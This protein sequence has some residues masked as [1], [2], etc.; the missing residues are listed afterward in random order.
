MASLIGNI[1]SDPW[2][3]NLEFG[4]GSVLN[5]PTQTAVKTGTST[6]YRDA[7]AVGYNHEYVVGIWMGNVGYEPTDGVTGSLGASLALRA[8]FNEL[9][10]NSKTEPLFLSPKL[11][12]KDICVNPQEVANCTTYTE[13][14]LPKTLEKQA[15]EI[16]LPAKKIEI[17]RPTNGLEIALDPR[18]PSDKQAFEMSISAILESDEV[19]WKIDQEPAQR[20]VGPK[21]LWVIKKGEHSVKAV[22]WRDGTLVAQTEAR[23]LNGKWGEKKRFWTRVQNLKKYQFN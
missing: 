5:L 1:L 8:I 3:R 12:V 21:F 4:R 13:Y 2:A 6:D 18:V 22:V 23:M 10:K 11:V 15:K 20:V 17:F 19:K 9:T 7:W 16:K 14:F